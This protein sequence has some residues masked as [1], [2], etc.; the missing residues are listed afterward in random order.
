MG[1]MTTTYGYSR[2]STSEQRTDMQE[3][4]LTKAGAAQIFQDHGVSGTTPALD[5]GGFCALAA[6]V[7]TGDTVLV[8]SLSRLGRNT[9][10]IL[11]TVK[12]F[13]DRGVK[14]RSVTE[15]FDTST[16]MGRAM[17]SIMATFA[18]LE[19]EIT[20]ERIKDGIEAAKSRGAVCGRKAKDHGPAKAMLSRGDS[21]A[22]VVEATG[23]SAATVRRIAKSLRG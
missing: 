20:A 4:A 21:T 22:S 12:N 19:R 9:L 15:G 10:D 3:D 16:P 5:R 17:L 1:L 14:V 8:Y 6:R 2:V 23:L 13:D 18:Q 11:T 7:K